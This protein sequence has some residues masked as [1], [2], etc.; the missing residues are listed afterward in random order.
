MVGRS[1]SDVLVSECLVPAACSDVRRTAP[2]IRPFEH[3]ALSTAKAGSTM[4]IMMSN[5]C[6]SA[7]SIDAADTSTL[8]ADTG[9]ESLP[10]NPSPSNGPCT[11]SPPEPAGTSQMVLSPSAV[12]GLD[13]HTY[14]VACEADVTQL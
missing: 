4:P 1:A 14:A 12:A 5:P 3:A 10:R 11:A 8:V 6:P 13:D 7:P 9:E 2:A